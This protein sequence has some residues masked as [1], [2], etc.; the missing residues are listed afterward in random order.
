MSEARDAESRT[1]RPDEG[2]RAFWDAKAREN[3]MYYIHSEL[4]YAH[5]DEKSFWDSG[6]DNLDRTLGPFG[7]SIAPTDRVVEIGC[8]I[9]RMTRAIAAQAA[10]VVGIDVSAEMIDRGRRA[11][12]DLDNVELMV[13]NG[14]DLHGIPDASADVVY[15]FI[16]F[17]H[18]PDPAITCGYI[19]EIGRVLRPG[20]WT[21]FQVSEQPEIHRPETWARSENLRL[22]ISQWLGR[23]PKGRLDP[24]WLGS[25]LTRQ[26]LLEALRD[27]GLEVI[28]TGGDG[29]QYCFVHAR[30]PAP[31]A[32]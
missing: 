4:D 30:R 16:V 5:V 23:A 32:T 15:S 1:R 27:G 12:A 8:G 31:G 2:M 7:V 28:S 25:A 26:Q 9:G 21:V 19:R 18:I 14:R 24:Q 22:K 17:Q 20:G 10:H 3:A 13:G 29:T 11:L 6:A